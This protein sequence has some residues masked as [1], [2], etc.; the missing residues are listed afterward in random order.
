[1]MWINVGVHFPWFG[2]KMLMNIDHGDPKLF[3]REYEYY[4]VPA[5]WVWPT[6]QSAKKTQ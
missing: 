6:L 5:E 3:Y 4:A 1:M 2:Y